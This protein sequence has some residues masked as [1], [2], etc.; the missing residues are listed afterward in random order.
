MEAMNG[1]LLSA[2]DADL[3]PTLSEELYRLSRVKIMFLGNEK[4]I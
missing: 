4:R 3:R 1:L 2:I